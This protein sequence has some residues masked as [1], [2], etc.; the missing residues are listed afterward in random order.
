MYFSLI[1]SIIISASVLASPRPQL[2]ASE[3]PAIPEFSVVAAMNS[4]CE[5]ASPYSCLCRD[6]QSVKPGSPFD[7]ETFFA[8]EP[9]SC[10]CNE[11]GNEIPVRLFGCLHGGLPACKEENGL[12]CAGGRNDEVALD[13]GLLV[14]AALE[15]RCVCTDGAVPVCP[16]TGEP[17]RC[18]GGEKP[19]SEVGTLPSFMANCQ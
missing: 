15:Q 11:S 12:I 9:T 16:D 3:L 10:S 13:F 4:F 1:V 7:P 6:G 8:C 5:G 2:D 17:P 19:D 18:P 14:E